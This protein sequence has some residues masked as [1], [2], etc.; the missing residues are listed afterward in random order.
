ME[1][2]IRSC[3]EVSLLVVA[4]VGY[5]A[6]SAYLGRPLPPLTPSSSSSSNRG[7]MTQPQIRMHQRDILITHVTAT[8]QFICQSGKA[9]DECIA[10]TLG[11]NHVVQ[12]DNEHMERC[13][14][15]YTVCCS[16][17]PAIAEC[18]DQNQE[19]VFNKFTFLEN[20]A[21]RTLWPTASLVYSR[22]YDNQ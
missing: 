1:Q 14:K 15:E 18:R 4:Y 5:I 8:L 22:I 9:E 19:C 7:E 17:N 20:Y 13:T 11:Y 16:V 21:K 12:K 6:L 10:L 3:V 2:K